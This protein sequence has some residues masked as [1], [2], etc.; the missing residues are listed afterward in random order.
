MDLIAY[1]YTQNSIMFFRAN[2]QY[3]LAVKGIDAILR[4]GNNQLKI[5]AIPVTEN[6]IVI[7]KNKASEFKK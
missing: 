6:M 4:Y 7:S 2:R 1:I 5:N 3:I